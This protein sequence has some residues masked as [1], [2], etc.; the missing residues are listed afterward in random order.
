MTYFK[1]AFVAWMAATLAI[2]AWIG[3]VFFLFSIRAQHSSGVSN[4]SDAQSAAAEDNASLRIQ[5]LARSTKNERTALD[6]LTNNDFLSIANIIEAVGK[7]SGVEINIV[8]VLPATGA[9]KQAKKSALNDVDF[10]VETEG[11]FAALIETASLF[12]NLPLISSVQN[13]ELERFLVSGS[14][15][16]EETRW[17]LSAR[18]RVLTAHSI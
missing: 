4:L 9:Q 10:L 8:S 7:D 15:K 13:L 17:R 3:A 18:I 5:A 1:G 16:K 11:T 12:E 14:G 2:L 6:N